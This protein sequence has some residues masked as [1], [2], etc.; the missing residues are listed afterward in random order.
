MSDIIGL[1]GGTAD[2]IKSTKSFYSIFKD[3]KGQ[4]EEFRNIAAKFPLVLQILENAEN[5]AQRTKLDDGARN[6]AEDNIKTCKEKVETLNKIFKAVLRK[7][8]DN[9]L[10]RYKKAVATLGK[11]ERAE[12]LM[13]EIMEYI[14]LVTCD[15]LMGTATS[16]QF[17]QL[18]EAIQEMLDL[19]SSITEDST[20]IT[21]YHTGA[22]HNYAN[23][24]A[25]SNTG[26]APQ[27]NSN[28]GGAIYYNSKETP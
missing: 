26:S 19:P 22:G 16:A 21:Q 23:T 12:Q 1:L 28:A 14:K 2:L 10:E 13:R 25:N 20:S 18:Q 17:E 3:A 24:I 9:W 6:A 27:I 4:P 11:G 15:K 8:D 7:D 5:E